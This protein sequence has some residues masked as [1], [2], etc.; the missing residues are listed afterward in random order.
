MGKIERK[1]IV[2]RRGCSFRRRRRLL[3][4]VAGFFD[5]A[6]GGFLLGRRLVLL[7]KQ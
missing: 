4:L 7:A 2:A 1:I 5:G 3:R 6:R